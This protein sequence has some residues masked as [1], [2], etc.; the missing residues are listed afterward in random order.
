MRIAVLASLA[1]LA[2]LAAACNAP[3]AP[4]DSPAPQVA[5]KTVRP[6]IL[7][8]SGHVDEAALAALGPDRANVARSPVPVLAPKDARLEDPKVMI[9]AEYYAIAGKLSGA[10]ISIQGT[11]LAHK[12]DTIPPTPGDRPMRGGHGFVTVN[13]GIRSASFVENGAAYSVDVEC[14]D[15]T[16]DARCTGDAFVLGLVESLVYVGGSER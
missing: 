6:K 12:Y 9:D 11:R 13:E 14:A 15:P 5:G 4:T 3:P 8:P 10:T 1:L 16:H 7:W 2:A